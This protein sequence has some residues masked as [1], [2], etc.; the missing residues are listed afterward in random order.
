MRFIEVRAH[1]ATGR[2]HAAAP[3]CHPAGFFGG[4]GDAVPGDQ[5]FI[6]TL[7][8]MSNAVSERRK[9]SITLLIIC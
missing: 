8:E 3:A 6:F 9:A 7:H 1:T 5:A 2:V 4:G